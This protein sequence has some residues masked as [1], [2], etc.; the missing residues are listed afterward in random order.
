VLDRVASFGGSLQR[1]YQIGTMQSQ[2][3][4]FL[5]EMS[6]GQKTNPE[7][8]LG[9]SAAV[10]YQLQNQSDMETTLQTSITTAS[11]RLD[12][13][14]TALSSLADTT[15]TIV[16]A[17]QNWSSNMS[18][19][20]GVVGSQAKSAIGQVLGLLNTQFLGSGVFAGSN[21]TA[22]RAMVK[23]NSGDLNAKET[24]GSCS[25]RR[26]GRTRCCA[27]AERDGQCVWPVVCRV[28]LHQAGRNLPGGSA[29]GG[30]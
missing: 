30:H 25:S 2:L 8:S 28:W 12:T 14:Q 4:Q 29:G 21:G 20:L 23:I 26:A 16:T 5:Q 11:D 19:G 24:S 15:Q 1:S 27:G 13:A 17:T 18:Q 6:T 22:P 10:L 3:T 9:T 7:A